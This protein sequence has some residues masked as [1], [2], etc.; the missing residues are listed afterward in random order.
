MT[1]TP[2]LT[3]PESVERFIAQFESGAQGCS[4]DCDDAQAFAE[5]LRALSAALTREKG[6][7]DQAAINLDTAIERADAAEAE[8]DAALE[9]LQEMIGLIID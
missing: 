1:N 5:D 9:V 4:M 7:S 8:R 6:Y 3:A 2:D